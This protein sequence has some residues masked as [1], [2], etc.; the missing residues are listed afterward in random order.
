M[1]KL[2][3]QQKGRDTIL[4][5]ESKN[6]F[7]SLKLNIEGIK[8]FSKLIDDFI[9]YHVDDA[10]IAKSLLTGN[11]KFEEYFHINNGGVTFKLDYIND[12]CRF[13]IEQGHF[14]VAS[15]NKIFNLKSNNL[16]TLS[17]YLHNRIPQLV[18]EENPNLHARAPR[19]E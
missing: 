5:I 13:K 16:I 3:I 18:E 8:M 11:N 1:F 17:S 2:D 14:G 4:S 19:R 9:E 15:Q 7:F 12:N 6:Y 10:I